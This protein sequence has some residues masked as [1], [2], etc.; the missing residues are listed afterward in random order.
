MAEKKMLKKLADQLIAHEGLRLKPYLC[1]AGKLT[2]GVG[3]NLED[4]GITEKEARLLLE[5]DIQDCI[6]DLQKIFQDENGGFDFLPESVQMVLEDMRFNLGYNGFRTFKKMIQAVR[7]HDFN[8]ACREMQD[9]KWY[10]RSVKG[11]K[12]L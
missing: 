7:E 12:S 8:K 6:A 10:S 4:R 9:S 1:P 2:I 3:R 11:V 5:N